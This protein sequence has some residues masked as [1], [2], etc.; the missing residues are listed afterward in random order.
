MQLSELDWAY[1]TERATDFTGR[2]WVFERLATFLRGPGGVLLLLGD[3]GTGKT[4]L[5]A[6]LAWASAGG[7]IPADDVNGAWSALPIDAAYFCR[8]GKVDLLDVAQR[9]SDQLAE[10]LPQFADIRRASLAPEIQIS[11]IQVR[12]GPVAAGAS[13]AGARIDLGARGSETVFLQ[14]LTMPVK[15]LRETGDR[16]RVVLLI[17]ALDESLTSPAA[18]ALPRL[19]GAL[20]HVHLVV[21]SREDARAVRWLRDRAQVIDLV[22][23][24]PAGSDDV[25][26][27]L[28]QRLDPHGAPGAMTVLA[29]RI[30]GQAAGNFL[31]AYY[32]ADALVSAGGLDDLDEP[33]AHRVRLPEGGLPGIY[34]EFLRRELGR[35]NHAW[36][37]RFRPVLAALAVAQGEGLDTNQLAQVAGRL[38]ERPMSLDAV[39]EVTGAA[40]QFLDGVRPDGPFRMYHQSFAEFLTDAAQ[41][42]DWPVDAAG[43]HA[44]VVAAL[45]ERVPKDEAGRAQWEAADAYTRTYLS[46]H[47]ARAGTLDGLLVDSAYLLA[48]H[49][50]PLLG[51]LGEACSRKARTA[52]AAYRRV[53]HRLSDPTEPSRASYLQLAALQVG[54]EPL[55]EEPDGAAADSRGALRWRPVW[56]WWQPATPNR[57]LGRLLAAADAVGA[58]NTDD[59]PLVVV[60]GPFG[61]E[62]WEIHSAQRLAFHP[63]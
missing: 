53:A 58:V 31:Y 13:V 11:D 26:A 22:A 45:I 42:P 40:Q 61:L 15:R 33:A 32:V 25:L 18:D 5:A 43:T 6:Q 19:L 16:T 36:V 1:V 30:A 55:V 52:A 49:P 9:L 54:A 47:A 59:D 17:D 2:D 3:P 34:R 24:A 4:A 10:A 56:S 44:A 20:E 7:L 35:D 14:G 12:T 50:S 48:A 62:V 8:A 29:R 41:N 37:E 23:D 39:R 57:V 28:H 63:W 46:A 27:Y 21:T 51:V 38:R 60:G